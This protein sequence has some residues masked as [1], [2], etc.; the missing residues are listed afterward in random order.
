MIPPGCVTINNNSNVKISEPRS[1]SAVFSN[2]DR[3]QFKLIRFDG[4]IKNGETACDWIVEK[5][6]IGRLAVELKGSDVDHAVEQIEAGLEYL[7]TVGMIDLPVAGLVICTRYPSVDTKVQRL[8]LRMAKKFGAPLKVR[9]DGR[10]LTFE[11]ML[12]FA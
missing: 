3:H 11:S 2:K 8:S 12:S 9:R 10:N 6:A 7:R 4:C 5:D 1:T